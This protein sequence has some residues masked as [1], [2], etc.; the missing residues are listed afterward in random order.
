MQGAFHDKTVGTHGREDV[1]HLREGLDHAVA[2]QGSRH[3][4]EHDVGFHLFCGKHPFGVIEGV[5]GVACDDRIGVL[6]YLAEVVTRECLEIEAPADKS[7]FTFTQP[8]YAVLWGVAVYDGD[9]VS[10]HVVE[11][12]GGKCRDGGF[13][14]T[15]FLCCECNECFIT[16]GSVGFNG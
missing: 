8:V 6:P 7:R 15:P 16:H 12:V 4:E 3:V 2:F 10:F 9:I 11:V 5:K 13:A 1:V 14:D